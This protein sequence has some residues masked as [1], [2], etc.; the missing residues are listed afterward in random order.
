M[1]LLRLTLVLLLLPAVASAHAL[2][3]T[4]VTATFAD[5]GAYVVD[6][7]AHP[8]QPGAAQ[9]VPNLIGGR[10]IVVALRSDDGGG[11]PIGGTV[12]GEGSSA[13][14]V[15]DAHRA[16]PAEMLVALFERD[17]PV[18]FDGVA[19]TSGVALTDPSED[20]TPVVR[21]TGRVPDGAE[22]FRWHAPRELGLSRVQASTPGRERAMDEWVKAGRPSNPLVFAAR[23]ATASSEGPTFVDWV[24]MGAA[25]IVPRGL[26]HILFVLAL[27]LF[28][29]TL[30]PLL[31]QVTAFTVAHSVTLTLAV[32]GVVRLPPGVH[33]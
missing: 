3:V 2:G 15:E 33:D 12:D 5:D 20:G 13:G 29:A 10:D 32:G 9:V 18:R 26:D 14:K 22:I 16:L 4:H 19:A 6:V 7:E 27:F 17:Q 25:H 11:G 1:L 24:R 23:T 21:L 28:G 8:T 30:R 31:L